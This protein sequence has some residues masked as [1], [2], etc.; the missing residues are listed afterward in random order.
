[1]IRNLN[2]DF[3]SNNCLSAKLT[4]NVYPDKCTYSGYRIGFNYRSE[5]LFLDGSMGKKVII[6]GAAMSS[7]VYIDN[8][9]KDL[10]IL[11]EEPTPGL[12]DNT[13]TSEAIYPISLAQM[14][15]RFVLSLHYNGNNRFLF[16]NATKYI[17]SKQEEL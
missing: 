2:T 8:K 12:D 5:F 9:N 13:L 14:S 17:N 6:F 1:M 16:V 4:K 3:T 11:G 10:L 15:K 7:S